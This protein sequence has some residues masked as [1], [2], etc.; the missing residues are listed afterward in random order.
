MDKAYLY[1]KLKSRANYGSPN[2][3]KLL[4]LTKEEL[5]YLAKLVDQ[6]LAKEIAA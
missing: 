2:G 5:E 6:D 4:Q 1:E 3:A